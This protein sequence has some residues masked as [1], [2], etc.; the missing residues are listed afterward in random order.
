[1]L[2][3]QYFATFSSIAQVR[4]LFSSHSSS[5]KSSPISPW[6]IPIFFVFLPTKSPPVRNRKSPPS[7]LPFSL[8]ISIFFPHLFPLFPFGFLALFSDP[9]SLFHPPL[10]LS[11]YLVSQNSPSSS[12]LAAQSSPHISL[13]P[14]TQTAH[15]RDG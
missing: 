11:P 12:H 13:L 3:F 6:K 14:L 7:S 1:M 10:Q 9:T 5:P 8:S 4:F 2:Y 15:P